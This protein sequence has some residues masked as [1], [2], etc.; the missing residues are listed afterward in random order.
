MYCC[1]L[2]YSWIVLRSQVLTLSPDLTSANSVTR[3]SAADEWGS[4]ANDWDSHKDSSEWD[5]DSD[6]VLTM[7]DNNK[8][9]NE[10]ECKLLEVSITDTSSCLKSDSSKS[11]CGTDCLSDVDENKQ[12]MVLESCYLYVIDEP[13]REEYLQ[14]EEQLLKQ[15]A[16]REGLDLSSLHTGLS[17]PSYFNVRC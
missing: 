12:E 16:R 7:V 17:I 9:T 3:T 15:Y 5:C 11:E 1:L 4:E 14:H 2:Y 13:S 8:T 10:I 6:S